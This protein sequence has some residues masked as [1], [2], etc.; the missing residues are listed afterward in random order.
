[1]S[2]GG[3]VVLLG[4]SIF[5]NA[6]YVPGEPS[7]L[8][9]LGKA[10]PTGWHATLVAVDGAPLAEVHEQLGR[11][12]P[13]ATHLFVSAGGND[14]LNESGIL[15][16]GVA[17]VGE[18]MLLLSQTRARFRIGYTRMAAA[19]LRLGKPS[20]FCTVYDAIPGLGDGARTAL[21]AFNDVI[22]QAAFRNRAPLIDLRL[23]C[24]EASDY[25]SVSEIEP[26]AQG[27]AKIAAVI[28]DV[29]T[30]HDFASRRTA[31]YP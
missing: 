13:E 15:S 14:A 10:L 30:S 11:V 24:D 17:T 28:A 3:H 4:D 31:V 5:D 1:M 20:V 23:V 8:D 6:R 7:V 12:R 21:A 18:A 9:H 29:A 27:G 25:S 26:S 19:V 2:S 16:E 22:V